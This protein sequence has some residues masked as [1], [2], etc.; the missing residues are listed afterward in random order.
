M[1]AP[2]DQPGHVAPFFCRRAPQ[3][4]QRLRF[5]H[6]VLQA[7]AGTVPVDDKHNARG[8]GR[9]PFHQ[10]TVVRR[11]EYGL[12]YLVGL[13]CIEPVGCYR[14]KYRPLKTG[15]F[16]HLAKESKT[17]GMQVGI[18]EADRALFH[19][20]HE[21]MHITGTD[22]VLDEQ[23]RAIAGHG[24]IQPRVGKL[25][26]CRAVQ[27]AHEGLDQW[28]VGVL[29]LPDMRA[30]QVLRG[31]LASQGIEPLVQI[32]DQEME[33]ISIL[34][35]SARQ[36][37]QRRRVDPFVI[38]HRMQFFQPGITSAD[39]FRKVFLATV[40]EG[41]RHDGEISCQCLKQLVLLRDEQGLAIKVGGLDHVL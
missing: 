6:E 9:Q 11:R 27:A 32:H 7:F 22:V 18:S 26:R 37:G 10:P 36:V 20:E 3:Q 24:R 21:H 2:G 30:I 1:L 29:D 5:A 28:P 41:P 38:R 39:Q 34:A 35:A 15:R 13:A 23:P 25:Q 8:D 14:I 19:H 16:E 31:N 33:A 40:A 17:V 12:A 4:R